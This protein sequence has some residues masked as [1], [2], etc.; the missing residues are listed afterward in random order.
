VTID[1]IGDITSRRGFVNNLI[2]TWHTLD[3][4][5]TARVHGGGLYDPN[6]NIVEELES[7][8]GRFPFEVSMTY[9]ERISYTFAY[10]WIREGHR[11]PV[12]ARKPDRTVTI[13][14]SGIVAANNEEAQS[15]G[16]KQLE[17]MAY[18]RGHAFARMAYRTV[19][20]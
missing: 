14:L 8:M 9:R 19:L 1:N 2:A 11:P 16:R 20:P 17:A 13:S 4:I 5:G 10:S 12:S 7:I 18:Q 6:Y 15:I 3:A